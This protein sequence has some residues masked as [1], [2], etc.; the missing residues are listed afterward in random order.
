VTANGNGNGQDLE[1]MTPGE[2]AALF[3]VDPKTVTKWARRGKLSPIRTLGGHR[4]YKTADIRA[5]LATTQVPEQPADRPDLDDV[6]R[7]CPRWRFWQ[8]VSGTLYAHLRHSSP[9]IVV[10]GSDPADLREKIRRE[11]ADLP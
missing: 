11:E 7:Q 5:L 3:R 6:A 8:G 2:V 9:P 1:L 10:R 4:R